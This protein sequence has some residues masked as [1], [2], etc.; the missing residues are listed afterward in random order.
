[1]AG[2]GDSG[3]QRVRGWRAPTIL[4]YRHFRSVVKE[5]ETVEILEEGGGAYPPPPQHRTSPSS[6]PGPRGTTS[7]WR[8]TAGLA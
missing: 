6:W 3:P 5:E 8:W 7:S 4:E 1:M 2:G